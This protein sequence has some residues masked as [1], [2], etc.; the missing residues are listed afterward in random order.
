MDVLEPCVCREAAAAAVAHTHVFTYLLFSH[1]KNVAV[2]GTIEECNMIRMG[3]I[4]ERRMARIREGFSPSS[5]IHKIWHAYRVSFTEICCLVSK[6][7]AK[8]AQYFTVAAADSLSSLCS[9][10]GY[11]TRERAIAR[12]CCWVGNFW[13]FFIVDDDGLADKWKMDSVSLSLVYMLPPRGEL[14]WKNPIFMINFPSAMCLQR[15][16]NFIS[17]MAVR[18]Q[19]IKLRLSPINLFYF[20]HSPRR[21]PFMS[22]SSLLLPFLLA[23]YIYTHQF[24]S[25]S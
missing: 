5:C 10:L 18:T 25:R 13:T 16:V 15:N 21:P 19:I 6:P 4:S 23:P 17:D 7:Q 22:F 24:N 11:S 2:T 1:W 14:K 12:C 9:T 8:I 20:C 3:I